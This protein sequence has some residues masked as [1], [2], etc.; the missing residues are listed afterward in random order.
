M[1]A[2]TMDTKESSVW[3]SSPKEHKF[4][5]NSMTVCYTLYKLPE[6]ISYLRDQ[7]AC[8]VNK[9]SNVEI[10]VIITSA[11]CNLIIIFKQ[12]INISVSEIAL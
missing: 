12:P 2:N 6:G 3:W 1:D 4:W 9:I 11:F 8:V 5:K 7:K 10:L